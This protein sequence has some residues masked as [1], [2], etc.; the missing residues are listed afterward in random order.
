MM[1]IKAK[2]YQNTCI[3]AASVKKQTRQEVALFPQTLRLRQ[4]R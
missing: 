3:A 1:L 2:K 4:K